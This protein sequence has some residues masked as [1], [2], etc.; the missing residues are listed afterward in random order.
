MFI[1]HHIQI[2]EVA[3]AGLQRGIT[4]LLLPADYE[5][6]QIPQDRIT[7]KISLTDILLLY[8]QIRLAILRN[9]RREIY[10]TDEMAIHRFAIPLLSCGGKK[11]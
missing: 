1:G 11:V 3:G 5:K 9:S 8:F 10:F 6:S 4:D 7:V 2:G